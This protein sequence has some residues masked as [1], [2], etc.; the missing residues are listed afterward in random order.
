[1]LPRIEKE[2]YNQL[3][4]SDAQSTD[5]TEEWCKG[6][7][8]TVLRR[9]KPRLGLWEAY[10][11]AFNSGIIKSDVI[12]TFSPDGNSIPEA[13]PQLI[14]KINEGYDMVIASRYYD[15]AKSEDDTWLTGIG[16][17]IFTKMCSLLGRHKY[18]DAMVIYRAYKANIPKKLGFMNEPSSFQKRL[19]KSSDLYSWE[20][21]LSI[22][23]GKAKMKIG[24]IGANEPVAFRERRQNTFKHGLVLLEQILHEGLFWKKKS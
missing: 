1:M 10:M 7:G 9:S 13:I 3:I 19:I 22:R 2:W 21:S 12:I 8:Y 14:A 16:N 5:G 18:T 23:V 4:I 20:P 15:G 11:E 24:E 17:W 6:N